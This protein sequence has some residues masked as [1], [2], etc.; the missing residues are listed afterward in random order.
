MNRFYINEPPGRSAKAQRRPRFCT[1]EKLGVAICA[2][3]DL[4]GRCLCRSW[5]RIG[6]SRSHET[7]PSPTFGSS[8]TQRITAAMRGLPHR[9]AFR[10]LSAP[11]PS[12]KPA[13]FVRS[14]T[15]KR[16]QN[17][18]TIPSLG[19]NNTALSGVTVCESA[20]TIFNMH[21]YSASQSTRCKQVKIIAR[22]CVSLEKESKE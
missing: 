22:E 11:E 19:T 15:E 2:S 7:L 13:T 5:L 21:R 4:P 12:G 17:A 9:E 18:T 1:D 14:R 6:R 10:A 8:G 16:K 3:S 20:T